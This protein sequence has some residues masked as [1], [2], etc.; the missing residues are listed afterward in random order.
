MKLANSIVLSPARCTLSYLYKKKSS[1]KQRSNHCDSLSHKCIKLM[2][3]IVA[4]PSRYSPSSSLRVL[5]ETSLL[6]ERWKITLDWT[7]ESIVIRNLKGICLLSA[8]QGK[9]NLM[10]NWQKFDKKASSCKFRKKWEGM[11]QCKA[12]SYSPASKA[13]RKLSVKNGW[14]WPYKAQAQ[15]NKQGHSQDFSSDTRS[16]SKSPFNHLFLLPSPPPTYPTSPKF[17]II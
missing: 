12:N 1:A 15:P 10:R 6:T 7:C 4:Y 8:G 17:L 11:S 9:G 3:A 2:V 16:F 14:H 5:L 13:K